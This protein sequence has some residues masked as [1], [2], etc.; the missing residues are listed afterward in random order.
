MDHHH[1][2]ETMALLKK[3]QIGKTL[4]TAI[5]VVAVLAVTVP[6]VSAYEAHTINVQARVKERFNVVKTMRLATDAEIEEAISANV[7]FPD[8]LIRTYPPGTLDP[9]YPDEVP[10]DTCVV[11]VVTISICNPHTDNMTEVVVKDN[12]GAELAGEPLDDV[13]VDVDFKYH[14]RGKGK[15][16]KDPFTTQ[17]RIIWYVTF[18]SGD[19]ENPETVDNSGVMEPGECAY[20]E[21]LVWTKLNPAGHQEYT[22]PGLYTLNS[23]PTAKWFDAPPDEGGHQFSF[24]ADPLYVYAN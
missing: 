15:K 18:E 9:D 4:I 13:P 3:R 10:I 8:T 17:Y 14:S 6:L 23:G 16:E 21:L 12:F 11:W 24:D 22:S 5:T 2:K 20:V 19:V 7:T 1:K